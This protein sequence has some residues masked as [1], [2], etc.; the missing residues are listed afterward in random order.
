MQSRTDTFC[1]KG[2]CR[3]LLHAFYILDFVEQM[4]LH[5]GTTNGTLKSTKY[6]N[7]KVVTRAR[8]TSCSRVKNTTRAL[9]IAR[10]SYDKIGKPAVTYLCKQTHVCESIIV[11]HT[12]VSTLNKQD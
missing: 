8:G 10:F 11:R 4:K 7:N 2:Q 1:V 3:H 9:E 6:K 12:H 5:Y